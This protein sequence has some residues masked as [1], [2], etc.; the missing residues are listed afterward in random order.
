MKNRGFAR[1]RQGRIEYARRWIVLQEDY[2]QRMVS[3]PT[4]E[5]YLQAGFFPVVRQTPIDGQP[6]STPEIWYEQVG[7]TIYERIDLIYDR[8]MEIQSLKQQLGDIEDKIIRSVEYQLVQKKLPY[9]PEQL[10]KERQRLKDRINYLES[11]AD[12]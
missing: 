4:A 10:H 2:G 7:D 11:E 5:E 8:S 9:D 1:I 6:Y 12:E 3:N